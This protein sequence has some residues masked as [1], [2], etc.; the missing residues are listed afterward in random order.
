ML[1]S[2]KVAM[3]VVGSTDAVGIEEVMLVPTNSKVLGLA[4]VA[5]KVTW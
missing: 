2:L 5:V 4:A 1:T 3:P